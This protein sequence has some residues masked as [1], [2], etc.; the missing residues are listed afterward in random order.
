MLDH[1]G[2]AELA[3]SR[4]GSSGEQALESNKAANATIKSSGDLRSQNKGGTQG[5][6]RLTG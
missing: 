4:T 1:G 6:Q 5:V 2:K 3:R